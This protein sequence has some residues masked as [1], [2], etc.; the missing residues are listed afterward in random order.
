MNDEEQLIGED[1]ST[2]VEVTPGMDQS[3]P[4]VWDWK[5]IDAS[6]STKAEY[7]S[8]IHI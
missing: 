2:P 4:L 6:T 1:W 5:K 8:L 3:T 7:L